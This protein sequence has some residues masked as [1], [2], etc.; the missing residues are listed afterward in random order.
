MGYFA[1][2]YVFNRGFYLIYEE[3]GN[4]EAAYC[5]DHEAVTKEARYHK[6]YKLV[7]IETGMTSR[8]AI[9]KSNSKAWK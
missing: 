8:D 2:A 1:N 7:P 3:A 4:L 9:E 5:R 6:R